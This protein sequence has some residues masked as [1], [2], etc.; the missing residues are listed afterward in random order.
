MSFR[1]KLFLVF[2]ITVLASVSVVAYSVTHYT[3]AAF[4]EMRHATHGSAG[5]AIPK[6]I[7]AA[8]RE[9]AQQVE[10]VANAEITL[11]MAHRSGAAECRPIALCA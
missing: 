10:N 5:S 9:V 7:C 8:R 11:K 3:R 1:T 2:L 4:E 6:R